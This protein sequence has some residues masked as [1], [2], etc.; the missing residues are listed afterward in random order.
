MSVHRNPERR[1]DGTFAVYDKTVIHNKDLSLR[2]RGLH[3]LMLDHPADW[4][5]SS[6]R[7]ALET[8]EGRAAIR[9]AMKELEA[10]GLLK[11]VKYQTEAGTF[12][13]TVLVRESCAV[14][15]P[16]SASPQ[17]APTTGNR[18]SVS[19]TS[20]SRSSK[21]GLS[22][23]NVTEDPSIRRPS[24]AKGRT[25]TWGDL[26]E[27][28]FIHVE[29]EE[30]PYATKVGFGRSLDYVTNELGIE[31]ARSVFISACRS[32]QRGEM[33]FRTSMRWMVKDA[34]D[35]Y[36]HDGEEQY[37]AILSD[38]TILCTSPGMTLSFLAEQVAL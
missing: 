5:F 32:T 15:W 35:L 6:E 37:A 24:Q 29:S 11:R 30:L 28:A 14:A 9:T 34:L 13:T 19:R 17:V 25:A 1:A 8:T 18:T 22:L 16:E 2:A 36:G 7:I 33:N 4:D 23:S 26:I 38:D 10:A 12:A 3:V 20:V 21:E 27:E 31:T